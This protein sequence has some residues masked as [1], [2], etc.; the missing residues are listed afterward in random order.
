MSSGVNSTSRREG[1]GGGGAYC[2]GT[3]G[4]DVT[5]EAGGP[6]IYERGGED[7]NG[8]DGGGAGGCIG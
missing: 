6:Y 1:G 5:L 3:W 8:T 7:E 4:G 2:I